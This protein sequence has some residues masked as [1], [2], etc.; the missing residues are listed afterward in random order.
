MNV[1]IS[2]RLWLLID[3]A[4]RGAESTHRL[5]SAHLLCIHAR[6]KRVDCLRGKNL[7]GSAR[8][9]KSSEMNNQSKLEVAEPS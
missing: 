6:L 8:R 3:N 4:A 2:V 5:E 7:N 9:V 1:G